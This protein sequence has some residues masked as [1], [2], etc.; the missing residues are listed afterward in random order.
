ME[1]EYCKHVLKSI[2]VL[3]KHQNTA[4][5]CLAKQNKPAPVEYTCSFC[6]TDFT[7]KS[8]LHSHLKICKSNTPIVK[9]QLQVLDQKSQELFLVKKDLEYALQKIE[10]QKLQMKCLQTRLQ[11]LAE[12]DLDYALQKIEDQKSQLDSLQNRL[13][14]LA[15]KAIERPTHLNNI[16]NTKT[17]QNL[18]ITDWRPEVIQEKVDENFKLEHIEDGIK[19]VA[20]FA[21]K[22]II[23][24]EDGIKSY[25]CTDRSREVFIYKDSD[26]IVQKDI[27]ARKLKKAI[28]DP[29]IKKSTKLVAEERSRLSNIIAKEKDFDVT[30][31]SSINMTN[32]TN[33]F[34]EI[35]H[36]DET[37]SFSKEMAVLS[38]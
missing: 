30:T 6:G 15:E 11:S 4:K 21:S 7:L 20:R 8:T 3:K 16:G 14:S 31:S 2:G 34:Q 1:C 24:E 5:Y 33:K 17:T 32:L 9:E 37:T 18:I 38:M 22:Y 36:I 12:K 26:G 19:G 28:K 23:K 35:K 27:E 10:D 29:I 13:Q 25:Q